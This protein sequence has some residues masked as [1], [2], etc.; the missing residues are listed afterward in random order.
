MMRIPRTQCKFWCQVVCVSPHT[1][2]RVLLLAAS[3][4]VLR[5][6]HSTRRWSLTSRCYQ[7]LPHCSPERE[8]NHSFTIPVLKLLAYGLC[9]PPL[10]SQTLL[11]A[12]PRS[13]EDQPSTSHPLCFSWTNRKMCWS[14]PQEPTQYSSSSRAGG[15]RIQRTYTPHPPGRPA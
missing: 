5:D 13:E 4:L 11:L 8:R 15:N 14:G 12:V 3:G 10:P 1:G 9:P 7:N 2:L 6:L